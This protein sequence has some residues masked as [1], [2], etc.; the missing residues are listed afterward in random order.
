MG[1]IHKAERNGVTVKI[2]DTLAFLPKSLM[3][4]GDK[5]IIGYTIR[6]SLKRSLY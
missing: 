2:G 3:I 4:P 1:T 6:A 5:C